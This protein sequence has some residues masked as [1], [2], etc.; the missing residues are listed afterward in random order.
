MNAPSWT[1]RLYGIYI[2]NQDDVK[3]QQLQLV[4][5]RPLGRGHVLELE[6][7]EDS[8]LGPEI[9]N[10]RARFPDRARVAY[11]RVTIEEGARGSSGRYT[12]RRHN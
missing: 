6:V 12:R 2:M 5:H 4:L 3:L 10:T 9:R 8:H 7:L 1:L 11:K